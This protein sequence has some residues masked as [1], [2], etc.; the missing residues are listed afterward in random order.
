MRR[1]ANSLLAGLISVAALAPASLATSDGTIES[2]T[3]YQGQALVTRTVEIDPDANV[4]EIVMSNLPEAI[5]PESVYAEGANG[6]SIRSVR[7][8]ERTVEQDAREEVRALDEKLETI[9]AELRSLGS[10]REVANQRTHLL[11]KMENFSAERAAADL[12]TGTLDAKSLESLADYISTQRDKIAAKLL[13]IDEKTRDIHKQKQ[14]LTQKR[15]EIASGC[16]TKLRE[17]V[18]AIGNDG[19][20]DGRVL[21]HYLVNNATWSPSY[22]IRGEESTASIAVDYTASI[23]QRTGEDW[24]DVEIILS[25]ASPALIAGAPTMSPLEI[26]LTSASPEPE[27]ARFEVQRQ[28]AGTLHQSFISINDDRFRNARDN[29]EELNTVAGQIQAYEYGYDEKAVKQI[30]QELKAEEGISVAYVLAGLTSIPNRPD[31]QAVQIAALTMPAEYFKVA[32]PVLTSFVYN[33]AQSTNLSKL[34]LLAGPTVS[35]LDGR[36]VGKGELPTVAIGETFQAGFGIDAS[37]RAAR[38]LVS[39]DEKTQGGNRIVDMTYDLIIENFTNGQQAIRVYDRLPNTN[40]KETLKV[41]LRDGKDALSDDPTFTREEKPNGILRWDI[42]ADAES[43]KLNC[44]R[45][46]YSFQM[47]Y[48]KQMRIAGVDDPSATAIASAAMD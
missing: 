18:V 40:K 2:V 32:K 23:Q 15:S 37:L 38:E 19:Q 42:V 33:E 34:V 27:F 44:H 12:A 39:K 45:V 4:V 47:E 29:S 1:F 22:T 43:N 17:A 3:V 6:V 8:R 20:A 10:Q 5:V 11:N 16:T 28:S 7:Y 21:L 30:Q 36:F 9:E 25:T 48:D 46:R 41:T 13:D 26:S 24:K 31:R 35:Y 14:L